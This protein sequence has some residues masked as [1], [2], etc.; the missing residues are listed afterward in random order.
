MTRNLAAQ[1]RLPIIAAAM[2]LA[3]IM[4]LAMACAQEETG[5]ANN[6]EAPASGDTTQ[7]SVPTTEPEA[8]AEPAPAPTPTPALEVPIATTIVVRPG[9]V[10]DNLQSSDITG[11][12]KPLPQVTAAPAPPQE[13]EVTTDT[14]Q[15]MEDSDHIEYI[16]RLLALDD[17]YEF[18]F[19][20]LESIAADPELA[21]LFQNLVDTWSGW[22][23]DWSEEFGLT[24]EDAAFAVS[25]PGGSV[26]LGG[27][28]DVEG[29]RE[30]LV[31]KG[32]QREEIEGVGYWAHPSGEGENFTFLAHNVVLV[33]GHTYFLEVAG[34]FISN[35]WCW[36]P[37]AWE[38]Y[39]D[40]QIKDSGLDMGSMEDFGSEI[41]NSLVFHFDGSDSN[42]YTLAKASATGD[43]TV[44]SIQGVPDD[45]SVSQEEAKALAVIK[46]WTNLSEE[47][48]RALMSQESSI[49]LSETS[50][51]ECTDPE[52]DRS[53]R[54][55]IATRVC[56]SDSIDLR[57]AN[58]FLSF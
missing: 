4:T 17:A 24:L 26:Y 12:P 11:Q 35:D 49:D 25:L 15:A 21:P 33:N 47:I 57:Y 58:F 42:Q 29:L 2:L 45:G 19:V 50:I 36:N 34:C 44:K 48:T 56:R 18:W 13:Q 30:T 3:I 16:L 43:L 1:L 22:N 7:P 14:P 41:R 8:R 28:A 38:W 40:Y 52:L 9:G 5:P 53:G 37:D 10:L 23:G 55:M 20:D 27:I 51:E 39:R 46:T 6:Q 54:T 32:Y 31:G